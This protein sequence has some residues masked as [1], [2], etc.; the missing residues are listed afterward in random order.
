M[1][2]NQET[3]QETKPLPHKEEL[4]GVGV[5]LGPGLKRGAEENRRSR[6]LSHTH[7]KGGKTE[8]H[9]IAT[10]Q[11]HKN[12]QTL[13][14]AIERNHHFAFWELAPRGELIRVEAT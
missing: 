14:T 9:N 12:S 13:T 5:E 4:S 6:L 8:Q 10:Q 7:T 1:L 3:T 2:C 11:T